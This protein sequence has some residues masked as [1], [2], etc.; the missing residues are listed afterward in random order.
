MSWRS[1]LVVS[2][3]VLL[4]AAFLLTSPQ[5][6]AGDV[7]RSAPPQYRPE[8]TPAPAPV[9]RFQS[10]RIRINVVPASPAQLVK[11]P[12]FVDLRGP[13]GQVRRFPV[14]G[15]SAAIQAVVLRP[16]QSLT[17]RWIAAK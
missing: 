1:I 16:G 12:D 14:V 17:V 8:P 13:D 11:D 7:Y 6:Q 3:A 15:G 4:G 10:F 5:V 2:Q 9:S